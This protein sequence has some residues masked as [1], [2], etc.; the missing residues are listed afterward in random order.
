MSHTISDY[1]TATPTALYEANYRRFIKLFNDVR[2]LLPGKNIELLVSQID[3]CILEQHKYTT[4]VSFTKYL[5]TQE[6][7]GQL[8]RYSKV[9]MELRVCH[10]ASVIEVIAYQGHKPIVSAIT[11]PNQEML[12]LDEKKQLNRLLKEILENA[13]R[14]ERLVSRLTPCN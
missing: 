9:A 14:L 8:G 11:Y 4:V 3:L 2:D 6:W 1:G 10:D 5:V 12:H 13:I 7:S